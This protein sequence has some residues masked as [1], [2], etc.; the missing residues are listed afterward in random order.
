MLMQIQLKTK[1]NEILSEL[2]KFTDA[3]IFVLEGTNFG[4]CDLKDTEAKNL[5]ADRYI[6]GN[7][8]NSSVDQVVKEFIES[9]RTIRPMP[10]DVGYLD[11][12]DHVVSRLINQARDDEQFGIPWNQGPVRCR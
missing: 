10:P 6:I 3:E 8:N 7:I 1:I 11:A 5:G 4:A 2:K 9:K 12:F